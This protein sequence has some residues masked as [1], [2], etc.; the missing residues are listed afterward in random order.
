[1][2][3]HLEWADHSAF[4]A[5]AEFD[6]LFQNP[7]KENFFHP[8]ILLPLL[9]Q[10]LLLIAVATNPKGFRLTFWGIGLLGLLVL[11]IFLV[12]ILSLNIRII[13]STL[14]FLFLSSAAFVS[15]RR[16][17]SVVNPPADLPASEMNPNP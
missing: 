7:S 16:N 14:P 1:M 13:G 9:G 3:C 4:L 12:G 8:L 17:K 2:L 6:I 11:V 15:W 5:T 10:I